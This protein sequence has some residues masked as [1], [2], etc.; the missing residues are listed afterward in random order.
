MDL[1]LGTTQRQIVSSSRRRD[2]SWDCKQSAVMVVSRGALPFKGFY[3]W[4][5][6]LDA[7]STWAILK[8]LARWQG[9]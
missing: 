8:D 2:A 7:R 4:R 1:R 5:Y 9:P 6:R 3:T